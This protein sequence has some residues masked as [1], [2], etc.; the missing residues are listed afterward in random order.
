MSDGATYVIRRA[1]VVPLGLLVLLTL[2]LLVV[3][4]LQGQPL[5]KIVILALLSL[6]LGA[7]LVES[8]R[9]R[10]VVDA[11]GVTAVRLPRPRRIEFAAVTSLEAVKVRSRIFLTL[12]A[13][14]DEFLIISNSYAGFDRLLAELL[15][16]VPEPAI[17]AEARELS[18][19]RLDR[20]ADIVTAWLA[21]AAMLYI[22]AVQFVR[23]GHLS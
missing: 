14:D 16:K 4:L 19:G 21:V 22:L 2:V 13:G 6:P 18:G 23:A 20:Q 11:N 17:T 12:V 8:A 10:L 7:L 5:A 3:C 9:R 1:F 15:V